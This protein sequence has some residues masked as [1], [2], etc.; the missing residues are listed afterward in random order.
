MAAYYLNEL[1]LRLTVSGDPNPDIFSCYSRCLKDLHEN[2]SAPRALRLFELRLLQALGYGLELDRDIDSGEPLHPGLTYQYVAERGPSAYPARDDA[3]DLYSGRDLIALR[4][5]ALD[6]E[7]SLSAARRLLTR[8][9]TFYLGDRPL[10]TRKV[11][12]EIV[13]R[14]LT[15]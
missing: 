12:L 8:Q 15:L 11:L 9:L 4:E 14:G 2:M 5:Q 10:K 1:L 7:Q 3:A 6:D 13:G